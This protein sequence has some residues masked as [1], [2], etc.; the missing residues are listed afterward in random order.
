MI[1]ADPQKATRDCDLVL[2]V[3]PAFAHQKYLEELAPH[4]QPGTI[5][6]GLPGQPG[7]DFAV[8]DVFS[9]SSINFTVMVC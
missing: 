4:L 7:F 9:L 6:V 2:L 8:R 1:T 5:I 3:V